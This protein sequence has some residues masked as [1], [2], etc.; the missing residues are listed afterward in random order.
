M[1]REDELLCLTVD[2]GAGGKGERYSSISDRF[3]DGR[4]EHKCFYC[5][6]AIPTGARYRVMKG[7]YEGKMHVQRWCESC[8]LPLVEFAR[9]WQ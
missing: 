7:N 2:P 3:V 6:T 1:T 4:K 5:S 9:H 8:C